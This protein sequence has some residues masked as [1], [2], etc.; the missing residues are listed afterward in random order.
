MTAVYTRPGSTMSPH[1]RQRHE[2]AAAEFI[3]MGVSEQLA[4]RM[5]ALFLTRVALD[6][7][8]LAFIYKRDPL[9]VS[10]LYAAFNHH[11][12]LFL[13]HS[14]AEDLRVQGRWQ[15]MAR[16]NLRDE[17]YRIRRD[18]ASQLLTRRGKTDPADVARLGEIRLCHHEPRADLTADLRNC[19]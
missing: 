6:I 13:L 10:K 17:F 2:S 18:L 9:D 4:G 5:A 16:S 1:A 11:L 3:D 12:Q 15:A 14:G 19:G 7:A 8:D